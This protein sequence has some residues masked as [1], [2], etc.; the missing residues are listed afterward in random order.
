MQVEQPSTDE[1]AIQAVNLDG[2]A[3][4]NHTHHDAPK[5]GDFP[6][7]FNFVQVNNKWCQQ[8]SSS[9][10]TSQPL[11]AHSQETSIEHEG[12][13]QEDRSM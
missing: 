1:G 6:L 7:C 13:A 9:L 5:T 11:H 3:S 10:E 8:S 2:E 4:P 12:N